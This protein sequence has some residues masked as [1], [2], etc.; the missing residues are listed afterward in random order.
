MNEHL[1]SCYM[2]VAVDG[3]LFR[4]LDALFSDCSLRDTED[5]K[6]LEARLYTWMLER[7]NY[8]RGYDHKSDFNQRFIG[9]SEKDLLETLFEACAI[10]ASDIFP[11]IIRY[12]DG[13]EQYVGYFDIDLYRSD[14][15]S[16]Q[17]RVDT[18][19][20][21]RDK[22]FTHASQSVDQ[23][24]LKDYSE[25][26]NLRRGVK[27][28]LL[29]KP[30]E[31]MTRTRDDILFSRIDRL[32]GVN[33]GSNSNIEIE[34]KMVLFQKQIVSRLE[35]KYANELSNMRTMLNNVRIMSEKNCGSQ[36]S[37]L[38]DDKIK[39]V[40]KSFAEFEE[41]LSKAKLLKK[42]I[43]TEKRVLQRDE[44]ILKEC[45]AIK[46]EKAKLKEAEA[47]EAEAKK[48]KIAEYE[49]MYTTAL[50]IFG[51]YK[52]IVRGINYLS[53]SITT[54]KLIKS[55]GVVKTIASLG[56]LGASMGLATL[57]GDVTPLINTAVFNLNEHTDLLK[58][59]NAI[60]QCGMDIFSATLSSLVTLNLL[61]AG[62][63]G[64]IA[65]SKCGARALFGE[66]HA[67][68]HLFDVALGVNELVNGPNLIIK[69]VGGLKSVQ[70]FSDTIDAAVSTHS[71]E[72]LQ[73]INTYY[74]DHTHW[75]N[76]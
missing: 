36:L 16:Y 69:L 22:L 10:D 41:A 31:V 2:K 56:H 45:E 29:D 13:S 73:Q 51:N 68:V 55:D 33:Y 65:V 17:Q 66:R 47:K 64:G 74:I 28:Y 60:I 71:P 14:G 48:A 9:T 52:S 43:K 4:N 76:M 27:S 19:T 1:A 26:I 30:Y 12:L 67:V 6:F 44:K 46:A 42:Q 11:P 39:E 50:H 63:G 49:K 32:L 53:K 58:S 70:S 15:T 40:K 23:W 38:A 20:P 25:Y 18:T 35:I 24:S 54:K 34:E 75:I 62:I 72:L 5:G 59:D 37:A 8:F 61:G 57:K 21:S 3:Y 7:L